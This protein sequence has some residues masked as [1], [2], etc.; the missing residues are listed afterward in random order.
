MSRNL[1]HSYYLM[2][3]LE[4]FRSGLNTL[5]ISK[6]LSITEA[7]AYSLVSREREDEYQKR[8]RK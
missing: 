3:P 5:Q 2:T 1:E 6:F 4:L 7:Q 8:N